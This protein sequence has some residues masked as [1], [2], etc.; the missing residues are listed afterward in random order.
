MTVEIVF[1]VILILLAMAGLM[2]SLGYVY[3]RQP[4]KPPERGAFLGQLLPR[5][6]V[7]ITFKNVRV[8]YDRYYP[9]RFDPE[10]AEDLLNTLGFREGDIQ[11]AIG[12]AS[13][14]DELKLDEE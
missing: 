1:L 2:F 5:F 13:L 6:E 9:G 7:L 4:V 8:H 3:A 10:L 14:V 12:P 11:F